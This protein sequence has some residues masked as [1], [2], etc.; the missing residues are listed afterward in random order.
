MRNNLENLG[1]GEIVRALIHVPV[2]KLDMIFSY[3]ILLSCFYGRE[4]MSAWN[5]GRPLSRT[6]VLSIFKRRVL[7]PWKELLINFEEFRNRK[8]SFWYLYGAMAWSEIKSRRKK[9][10]FLVT[11]VMERRP[12]PSLFLNVDVC[13]TKSERVREFLKYARGWSLKCIKIY[14]QELQCCWKI[15]N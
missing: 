4:Y 10:P 9:E 12:Q 2:P 14:I 5:H 7:H 15:V 3:N 13:N 6:Y 8:H 1:A 11:K